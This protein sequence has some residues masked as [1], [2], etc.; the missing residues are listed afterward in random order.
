MLVSLLA[1]QAG[2]DFLKVAVASTA[3]YDQ[4]V[5]GLNFTGDLG[6]LQLPGGEIVFDP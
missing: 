5:Y 2:A 4:N 3:D 6:G 1:A